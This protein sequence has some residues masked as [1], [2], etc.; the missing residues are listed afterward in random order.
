V[1]RVRHDPAAPLEPRRAR[2]HRPRPTRSD[3]GFLIA[4]SATERPRTGSRSA[5]LQAPHPAG[6]T[7][8]RVSSTAWRSARPDL[9][10]SRRLRSSASLA[11]PRP[12]DS[13]RRSKRLESTTCPGGSHS[14]ISRSSGR[15]DRWNYLRRRRCFP[16]SPA[17]ARCEAV[18]AQRRTPATASTPT[19]IAIWW[20]LVCPAVHLISYGLR[21]TV[22]AAAQRVGG[23]CLRTA[24]PALAACGW[25]GLT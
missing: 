6:L 15:C 2:T 16:P 11:R 22:A 13:F 3:R 21:H 1:G 17:W 8:A 23:R 25:S 10:S 18:S 19:Q 24:L 5:A 7:C 4:P 9:S 12:T 14:A 20:R